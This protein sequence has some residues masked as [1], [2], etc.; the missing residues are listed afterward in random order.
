MP[1]HA[2]QVWN[3]PTAL[4]SQRHPKSDVTRQVCSPPPLLPCALCPSDGPPPLP[5]FRLPGSPQQARRNQPRLLTLASRAGLHSTL[6]VFPS[7][8]HALLSPSSPQLPGTASASKRKTVSYPKCGSNKMEPPGAK[9]RP[10]ATSGSHVPIP[11]P[12]RST[13]TAAY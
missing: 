13:G 4:D 8:T 5:V 12:A 9:S 3:L 6:C 11:T 7:A 1:A 10:E 2:P